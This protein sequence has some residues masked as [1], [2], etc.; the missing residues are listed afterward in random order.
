MSLPTTMKAVV[1]EGKTAVVKSD[2]PLPNL[3]EGY[4]MIQPTAVA[5]NPTDWKHIVFGLGPQGAIEGCDVA[6]KIVKMGS[7]VDSSKFH[8]GDFVYG[9]VHGASVRAPDNGAYAE[10]VAL[11][12]KL[13]FTAPST[14]ALSGKDTIPAGKI[15]SYEAA[16]SIPCAWTTA[17]GSLFHH[18]ALKYEWEPA[19][20]QHNFPILIWGGSSVL[21]QALIQLA[22]KYH[23]Y[24]KI[25]TVASKKHEQMLKSYGADDV[26][27][28]HDADVIEQ[29]KAK[30]PVI[31]HLLDLISTEKTLNQ[32]YQCAPAT[33]KA[34]ILNYYGLN[35]EAI[36]EASRKNNVEIVNTFIYFSLGF[37]LPL[38]G[39]VLKYDP[40]YRA[41]IIKFIEEINPRLYNGDF[42]APAVTVYKNGLESAIQIMKDLE[43]GK[44]SGEKLVATFH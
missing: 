39:N 17:G 13:A 26:F 33:E 38:G 43:A 21:G 25:I 31:P 1:I 34:T 9:F 35:I 36:P 41:D 40:Q 42:E 23:G 11:D 18:Y 16:A 4:L 22:K 6:G 32:V 5:G 28:Y 12:S 37:D 44:A 14:V 30:Y 19:Q 2:L 20:P 29:I 15:E 7:D 10:Y 27:D 8:L 24:T 3:P